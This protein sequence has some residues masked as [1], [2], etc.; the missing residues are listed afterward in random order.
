MKKVPIEILTS[1]AEKLNISIEQVKEILKKYESQFDIYDDKFEDIYSYLHEKVMM[2]EFG[3][4]SNFEIDSL[5]RDERK[6]I[7]NVIASISRKFYDDNLSENQK[8]YFYQTIKS[9]KIGE[10]STDYNFELLSNLHSK[11][12]NTY[13]YRAIREFNFL[14][15]DDKFDDI[16]KNVLS[17]I[18]L[19]SKIKEDIDLDIENLTKCFGIKE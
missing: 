16:S 17:Y 19:S 4:N 5:S 2:E 13:L 12:V 8:K 10:F 9:F 3:L 6:L 15:E 14:G 11:E 7:L 1:W 18:V